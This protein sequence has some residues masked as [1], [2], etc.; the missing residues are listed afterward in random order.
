MVDEEIREDDEEKEVDALDPEDL[1]DELIVDDPDLDGLD[2]ID[3]DD[4]DE[5][6]E[7]EDDDDYGFG[8]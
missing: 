3:E 5:E 2:E 6:D 7:E 1:G 4:D 8:D